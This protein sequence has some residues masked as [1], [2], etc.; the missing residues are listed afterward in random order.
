MICGLMM[1]TVLV[2]GT[3][4]GVSLALFEGKIVKNNHVENSVSEGDFKDMDED[5]TDDNQEANTEI[6]S[7]EDI[8]KNPENY[9]G[10]TLA[11]FTITDIELVT[12]TDWYN[13]KAEVY[14]V[15]IKDGNDFTCTF[16]IL[17]EDYQDYS[18]LIGMKSI[19]KLIGSNFPYLESHVDM[20]INQL[21]YKVYSIEKTDSACSGAWRITIQL[22]D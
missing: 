9:I 3:V 12:I 15:M 8:R 20:F 1:A 14:R 10:D 5:N 21:V 18:Q 19:F 17:K 7:L 2:I 4:I 6:I 22:F 16:H 13:N 11:E